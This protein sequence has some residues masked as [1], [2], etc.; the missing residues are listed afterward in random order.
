MSVS[1]LRDD[2]RDLILGK[3]ATVWQLEILL[4]L[5]EARPKY[6]TIAELV[7]SLRFE[8]E[9]LLEQVRALQAFGL[10]DQKSEPQVA[11]AYASRSAQEDE[12]VAALA[13]AYS[14]RPVAV[15]SLIYSRPAEK[16]RTFA[17]A[18]RLRQEKEPPS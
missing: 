18:F 11:F 1:S 15:I 13:A 9:S 10:A 4:H 7:K 14:N 16:I 8:R 17:D 2:V 12:A 6:V 3:I 5:F